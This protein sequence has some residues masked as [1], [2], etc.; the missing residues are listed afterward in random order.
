MEEDDLFMKLGAHLLA[1]EVEGKLDRIGKGSLA[2][3]LIVFDIS[4]AFWLPSVPA[5]PP[6]EPPMIEVRAAANTD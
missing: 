5:A 4:P 2:L 1:F 3:E 6:P